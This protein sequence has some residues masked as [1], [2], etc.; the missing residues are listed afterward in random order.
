MSISKSLFTSTLIPSQSRLLYNP[1]YQNNTT[2]LIFYNK[3]FFNTLKIIEEFYVK[4]MANKHYENI[5]NDYNKYV[6]LYVILYKVL[7]R[8]SNPQLKLLFKITQEALMGAMNSITIYGDKL[9]L[10]L[11]VNTLEQ[12]LNDVL[13][14]EN[15]KVV[16]IAN[17][18][19]E[20]NIN[21][22]FKL[23]TVFNDYILIYGLP[24][25]GVGFDPVKVE[26]L[27]DLLKKKGIDP[28]K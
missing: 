17:A 8:T 10:E 15:K 9:Y 16:E 7:E 22:S 4:N 3:S 14:L 24:E 23:A 18:T 26:F 27:A 19:G 13:L 6:T 2:D 21:K 11:K 20:L 28:Y 12:K 5:P 1:I 25:F